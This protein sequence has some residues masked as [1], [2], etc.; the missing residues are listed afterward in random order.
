MKESR[1]TNIKVGI[2]VIVALLVFIWILGW[3]KRITLAGDS[4][5]VRMKFNSVSGLENGDHITVNGVKKGKV[6]DISAEGGF[7]LVSGMLPNDV[8]L[9]SDAKARVE[10]MDLMGGK[11]IEIFPGYNNDLFDLNN[12]LEGKL[13]TDIP[14]ALQMIGNVE[15]EL[16]SIIV[17]LKVLLEKVSENISDEKLFVSLRNAVTNFEQISM[18]LDKILVTNEND[19]NEIV[20]NS[21]EASRKLNTLLSENSA[22]I[23]LTLHETEKLVTRMNDLTEKLDSFLEQT[24]QQK[25]NVGKIIYDEKVYEDLRN[26]LNRLNEITE[27]LLNQMKTGG[28]RVDT[29]VRFFE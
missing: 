20:R 23:K 13:A 6:T 3:A 22:S 21:A 28:I 5:T 12:N 19:I 29:K 14:G 17:D 8:K 4:Y 18:K 15:I 1:K 16:K 10:M 9:K 26:S 27:L 7:V 24:Q 11:K 2:T 25:N